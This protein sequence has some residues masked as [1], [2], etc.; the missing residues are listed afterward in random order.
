MNMCGKY[1][2]KPK[3]F[4]ITGLHPEMEGM[5]QSGKEKYKF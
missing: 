1:M 2:L 4:T 5:A 3:K